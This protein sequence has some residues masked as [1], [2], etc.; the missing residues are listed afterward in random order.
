MKTLIR[1]QISIFEVEMEPEP[2]LKKFRYL[3]EIIAQKYKEHEACDAT[4]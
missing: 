3:N 2:P 1:N 4:R